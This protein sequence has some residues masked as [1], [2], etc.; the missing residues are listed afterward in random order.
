[1]YVGPESCPSLHVYHKLWT[2]FISYIFSNLHNGLTDRLYLA[3]VEILNN[4]SANFTVYILW[5]YST[6]YNSVS[7]FLNDYQLLL[8]RNETKSI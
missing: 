6:V 3:G 8:T 2:N 5:H 7:L 1:M 4:R